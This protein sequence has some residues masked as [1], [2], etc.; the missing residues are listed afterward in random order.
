MMSRWDCIKVAF[1][2]LVLALVNKKEC[3]RIIKEIRKKVNA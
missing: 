3:E 2:F 1:A